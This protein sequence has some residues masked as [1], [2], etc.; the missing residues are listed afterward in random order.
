[1]VYL[2]FDDGPSPFTNDILS[3][4]KRANATAT[5]FMIG[6]EV[7]KRTE[8]AEA[9]AAAGHSVQNHTHNHPNLTKVSPTRFRTQIQRAQQAIVSAT[10]TTPRCLRPPMGTF[11]AGTAQR[12]AQQDLR[13]TLWSV[14]SGDW[15]GSSAAKI[16]DRVL[17]RVTN[18]SVV[19]MHDGGGDRS[20]TVKAVRAITSRLAQRGYEMRAMPS[21]SVAS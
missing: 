8:L 16:T 12:A 14:D 7:V 15:M 17:D 9:V 20:Q 10:G 11:N 6:Q 3:E 13:L 5:F 18:G 2:T 21:C 1:V 19:L 4:L